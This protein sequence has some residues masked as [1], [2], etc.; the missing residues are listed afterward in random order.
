MLCAA[1]RLPD[2]TARRDRVLSHPGAS[3]YSG[4]AAIPRESHE[5]D[6]AQIIANPEAGGVLAG[7]IR[8]RLV[9]CFPFAISYQTGAENISV[10][11]LMHLHRRP[12]DWKRR[13]R[14]IQTGS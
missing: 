6:L 7:T 10:I 3:V 12:G 13:M 4:E 9:W 8:R 14:D 2:P 1:H 11:A 5:H